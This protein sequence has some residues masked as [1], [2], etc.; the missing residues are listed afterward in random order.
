MI[1]EIRYMNAY[2][3]SDERRDAV[4]FR[5]APHEWRVEMYAVAPTGR[6][7]ST[8]T[9]DRLTRAQAIARRWVAR[10]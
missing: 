7:R 10:R 4:I 3:T 9:V 8:I 1:T 2:R 6:A 5:V